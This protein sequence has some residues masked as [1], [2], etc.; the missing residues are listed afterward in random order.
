MKISKRD[1]VQLSAFLD[2]ELSQ[3][4]KIQLE[5]RMK[6]NPDLQAA[7]NEFKISKLVLSTT[8]RIR[9]PRNF[10][11]SPAQVGVKTIKPV[12]RQYS[13]AA[14]VMSFAFIGILI[15]DIGG[16]FLRGGFAPAMAPMSEEIMLDAAAES[17]VEGLA[18]PDLLAVD[19]ESEM[20]RAAEEAEGSPPEEFPVPAA[21]ETEVMIGEEVASAPET[22]AT[23]GEE[24]ED[25]LAEAELNNDQAQEYQEEPPIVAEMP[26][27][28]TQIVTYADEPTKWEIQRKPVSPLRILE[29]IFGLGM[30]GFGG[31]AWVL[32]RRNH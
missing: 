7:L 19:P 30:I 15:F 1:L 11:L 20:D 16:S 6:T 27:Q 13:L 31:A 25:E 4:E 5:N 22:K 32:K 2:G 12:Y 14:A 17:A 8:P 24:S 21:E 29:I 10:T 3:R 23:S 28:Q 9:V 26:P 18:E